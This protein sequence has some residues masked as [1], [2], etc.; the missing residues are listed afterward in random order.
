MLT[1]VVIVLLLTVSV[2]PY[3]FTGGTERGSFNGHC[4]PDVQCDDDTGTCP[5]DGCG[6]TELFPWGGIA[7]QI[8]N[9]AQLGGTADQSGSSDHSAERCINGNANTVLSQGSC[10]NP[11]RSSGHL[12]WTVDLRGTFLL[13]VS[14]PST[15]LLVTL[16]K[17]SE[18]W[19][20]TYPPAGLLLTLNCVQYKVEL[21]WV[22]LL[23]DVLLWLAD[24]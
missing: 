5:G 10:C 22:P 15:P 9:G 14:S 2:A 13:L 17:Q 23:C 6:I 11:S 12:Y 3:T 1:S 20:C 19:K 8:G 18:V 16:S 21:F 4:S 7:C 24:T